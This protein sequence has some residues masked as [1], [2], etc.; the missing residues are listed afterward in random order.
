M[1]DTDT[2]TAARDAAAAHDSAEGAQEPA[3][4]ATPTLSVVPSERPIDVRDLLAPLKRK[5]DK[6]RKKEKYQGE[7]TADLFAA[8]EPLL[9]EPTPED[10]IEWPSETSGYTNVKLL[11]QIRF[12]DVLFGRR[13]W[14]SLTHPDDGG[15]TILAHIVIGNNLGGLKLDP[16]TGALIR[17]D[18]AE[19]HGCWEGWG[20]VNQLESKGNTLKGSAT[21]ALRRLLSLI[22]PGGDVFMMPVDY[23]QRNSNSNSGNGGAPRPARTRPRPEQ[24]A[25]AGAGVR[26]A[27]LMMVKEITGLARER[28]LPDS[29]LANLIR[30]AIGLPDE[31]YTE[32]LAREV[33]AEKLNE[34]RIVLPFDVALTL[35]LLVE[36]ADPVAPVIGTRDAA[37]GPAVLGGGEGQHASPGQH[38]PVDVD[39]AQ[40]A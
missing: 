2:Q 30:R 24:A 36:Q 8:L 29:Q 4:P 20:G 22:G 16:T 1:Q 34:R 32:T 33:L 31:P 38:T 21:S 3:L 18:V 23:S 10:A 27:S 9:D 11:Y 5:A 19:L 37:Q 40:A 13:H 14:R 7:L 12:M 39:G 35:R 28:K 26:K 17:D 6:L 15:L 25:V